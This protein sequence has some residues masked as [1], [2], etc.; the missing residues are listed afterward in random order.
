MMPSCEAESALSVILN[1]V[2]DLAIYNNIPIDGH[3]FA[4]GIRLIFH[5]YAT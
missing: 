4:L 3:V 1:E 2:T 5:I